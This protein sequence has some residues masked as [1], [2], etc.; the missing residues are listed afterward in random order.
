ML[1][2]Y[3]LQQGFA[4]SDP[5]VEE[6][7]SATRARARRAFVAAST[8]GASA[9]PMRRR[10]ASFA[11]GWRTAPSFSV[12]RSLRA[13]AW[14]GGWARTACRSSR[15]PALDVA[16]D[17]LEQR[18]AHLAHGRAHVVQPARKVIERTAH[19]FIVDL[20][21]DHVPL[22][23]Q[24]GYN[25]AKALRQN[26]PADAEEAPGFRRWPGTLTRRGRRPLVAGCGSPL[27]S[28]HEADQAPAS[29]FDVALDA[30]E[31][32][33]AHLAHG[34]AHVV[35]PARQ[36]LQH[37]DDFA[38]VDLDGDHRARLYERSS[39]THTVVLIPRSAMGVGVGS[40]GPL[41]DIKAAERHHAAAAA[42]ELEHRHAFLPVFLISNPDE[43]VSGAP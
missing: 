28:T 29:P 13:R 14:P 42:A 11:T 19:S 22:L 20:E 8:S 10:C 38:V 16:L 17:A 41:L 32:R 3:F 40:R 26:L 15:A 39:V 24:M 34:R 12:K 36:V 7:H 27:R 30:L 18:L 23:P 4:L 2:I 1:G 9:R 33:L 31:Q 25:K 43:R 21:F 37:V 6:G 35:E 5:A